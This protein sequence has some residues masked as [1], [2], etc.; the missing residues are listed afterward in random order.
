M[1]RGKIVVVVL[2]GG[3]ESTRKKGIKAAKQLAG[4]LVD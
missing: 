2:C 1:R 3:G 4:E